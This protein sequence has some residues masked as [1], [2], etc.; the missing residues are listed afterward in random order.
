MESLASTATR[1]NHAGKALLAGSLAAMLASACCIGPLVLIMV[2]VSGAWISHLAALEPYQPVFVVAAMIAL[3]FA[4]RQI[5]RP[6][7]ACPAGQVCA[8]A[9]VR[10]AHKLLFGV[11]VALLVLA[12]GFPLMAPW[13]Y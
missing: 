12:L 1:D 8:A 13:F 11:V 3:Y 7:E 5:W 2:G 10:C 4:A 9:P 6:A